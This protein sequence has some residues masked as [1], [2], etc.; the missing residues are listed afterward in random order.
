VL[1]ETLKLVHVLAVIVWV[2]GGIVLTLV[3]G[4]AWRTSLGAVAPIARI[5]AGLGPVFGAAGGIAFLA[6]VAM[7]VTTEGSPDFEEPWIAIGVVVYLISA[8]VG[9]RLI[10][11]R[12]G[13]LAAAAE[14]GDQGG[15]AAARSALVPVTVVDLTLLVI[16][17]AAMVYKW[18]A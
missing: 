8:V 3:L 16:A 18:G 4:R 13:R 9:A 10:G 2:G 14:A 11:P 12:Y 5:G 17:I 1:Y 15:A 7:V 6:G